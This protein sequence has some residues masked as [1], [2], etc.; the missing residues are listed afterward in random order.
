MKKNSNQKV[1]ALFVD[2]H[3]PYPTFKNVDCW[4]VIRDARKYPGSYPIVAH[5]PCGS[6]SRLA[7]INKKRWGSEIGADGGCFE[8]ALQF[9]RQYGGVIEHPAN[10]LAWNKFTL[11]KPFGIGWNKVPSWFTDNL[12]GKKE[13]VA[14]IWQSAYG[15]DATK[16]TWLYFVGNDPID[17]NQSRN[18]GQFQ[19]GGGVHSGNNKLP[20]LSQSQT[21][22][23]PFLFASFLI[24]LVR[25]EE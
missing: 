8:S 11:Q 14:E 13:Y 6:W 19:I 4:D 5:P 20:R 10:S 2:L 3:G 25:H 7:P 12:I 23:S 1:A 21:H 22:L 18:R 17:F 24:E 15:H 9:V 16:R